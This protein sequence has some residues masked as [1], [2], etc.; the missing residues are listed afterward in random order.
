MAAGTE[1]VGSVFSGCF[2]KAQAACLVHV[3]EATREEG[4]RILQ[5]P[6]CESWG[7]AR[8]LS[9]PWG[10][11][12]AGFGGSHESRHHR[13]QARLGVEERNFLWVEVPG[14]LGMTGKFEG[15]PPWGLRY[16][17]EGKGQP[18]GGICLQPQVQRELTGTAEPGT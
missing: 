15:M 11:Q 1:R 9:L 7:T 5:A 13:C 17:W 18:K 2:A 4:C 10:C 14:H 8:A 16:R 3:V 6:P 12:Q